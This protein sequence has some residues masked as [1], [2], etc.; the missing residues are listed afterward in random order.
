MCLYS[1]LERIH[2]TRLIFPG[3]L[4][5]SLIQPASPSIVLLKF[6]QYSNSHVSFHRVESF[7]K[8]TTSENDFRVK[9]VDDY[10]SRVSRGAGINKWTCP[11]SYFCNCG[12]LT[13]Y[14]VCGNV[15]ASHV[16]HLY[17]TQLFRYS[18]ANQNKQLNSWAQW[19]SSWQVNP[20][21][22]T[23]SCIT[24]QMQIPVRKISSRYLI[25][26]NVILKLITAS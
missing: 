16:L 23:S 20:H 26:D 19:T 25:E 11:A 10:Y 12:L 6:W 5:H 15:A 8:V 7:A 9:C 21:C 22:L 17:Y 4:Q 3:F 2:Q 18:T 14:R 24:K 1:E 13:A